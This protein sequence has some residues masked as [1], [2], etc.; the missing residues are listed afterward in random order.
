MS[1][2]TFVAARDA[3]KQGQLPLAI[4]LFEQFCTESKDTGSLSYQ[5]AQMA[6]VR[7]YLQTGATAKARRVN[8]FLL[9]STHLEV[10]TWAQKQLTRFQQRVDALDEDLE[11]LDPEQGSPSIAAPTVQVPS[12]SPPQ[13]QPDPLRSKACSPQEQP[14]PPNSSPQATDR[15]QPGSKVPLASGVIPLLWPIGGAVLAVVGILFWY[16]L[17]GRSRLASMDRNLIALSLVLNFTA[18]AFFLAPLLQDWIQVRFYGLRWITLGELERRSPES[19]RVLQRI[20][21]QANLKVPKLGIVA[22]PQPLVACYGSHPDGGRLVLSRGTFVHLADDEIAV[23]VAQSWARILHRDALVLTLLTAPLQVIYLAYIWTSHLGEGKGK[24]QNRDLIGHVAPVFYLLYWLGSYPYYAVSRIGTRHADHFAV[25]ATGNPN[26]LIRALIKMGYGQVTESRKASRPSYVLDGMRLLSSGD[27]RG[28][29]VASSLYLA[30]SQPQHLRQILAWDQVSPWASLMAF[31]ASHPLLGE[32]LQTLSHYA[33]RLRL[34]V[35]FEL[36]RLKAE[37]NALD[38]QRIRRR[39]YGELALY[40]A[41]VV[42]LVL[43]WAV[44]LGLFSVVRWRSGLVQPGILV[45][46]AIIGFGVGMIA[47]GILSFPS[48]LLLRGLTATRRR[49]SQQPQPRW[50]NLSPDTTTV[51]HVLS[52]PAASPVGLQRVQIKGILFG[53]GREGYQLGSELRLS[54]ETGI[55]PIR[56]VSPLGPLGNVFGGL[57]AVTPLMGKPVIVTGWLRRGTTPW[58]DLDRIEAG[59]ISLRS[60]GGTWLMVFGSG[61]IGLGI[62]VWLR[63]TW[64]IQY[65]DPRYWQR[66]LRRL[67]PRQ[68]FRR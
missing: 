57:N 46:C 31:N 10:Q 66:I 26:G 68:L 41:E 13:S 30:Q 6:L 16:L 25:E 4:R 54:D 9:N 49:W 33:E 37:G 61:M 67:S 1:Q 12:L 27:P 59:G 8:Q 28:G 39:F 42:G 2:G 56:F 23:L 48:R 36:S 63:Y 47:K 5:Q 35:A 55:L 58:L 32:R 65:V 7:A 53:R 29:A 50:L 64:V 62:V 44:G 22:D 15:A 52:D 40:G 51:A 17:L 34:P 18:A 11:E 24:R 14:Q 43:G 60:Y 3:F 19:A 20:C 45:G 38:R 21:A